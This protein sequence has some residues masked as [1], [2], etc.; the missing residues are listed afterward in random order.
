MNPD[1]RSA[2]LWA[3]N[4]PKVSGW[5]GYVGRLIHGCGGVEA[6]VRQHRHAPTSEIGQVSVPRWRPPDEYNLTLRQTPL[7]FAKKKGYAS[8]VIELGGRPRR[9]AIQKTEVG[10]R[11]RRLAP[12]ALKIT[13][14][15]GVTCH[16][17]S[18]RNATNAKAKS[19]ALVMPAVQTG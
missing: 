4:V 3:V 18:S 10:S 2:R 11:A 6:A 8:G 17:Y 9:A 15:H 7:S 5:R 14:S 12:V 19:L 16:M 1:N 13:T